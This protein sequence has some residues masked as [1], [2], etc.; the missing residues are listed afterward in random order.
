MTI[1]IDADAAPR[2][3]KEIVYRAAQRHGL[4]AVLVAH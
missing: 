4:S 2:E 3:V 1:W